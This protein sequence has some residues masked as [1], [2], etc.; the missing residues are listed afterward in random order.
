LRDLR[1]A[2]PSGFPIGFS[3]DWHAAAALMAGGDVWYSV[4]AG[5]YPNAAVR[6]A[7][8]AKSSDPAAAARIDA[9]LQPLWALFRKYT[10]YRV[11]HHVAERAGI[12]SAH[13]P[14]P[15]LPLRGEAARDVDRTLEELAL[16]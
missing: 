2:V 12:V 1:A 3:V 7:R 13:P 9:E 11:V 4:V 16:D 8:A 15:L 6:L 5:V 14:L 10:S